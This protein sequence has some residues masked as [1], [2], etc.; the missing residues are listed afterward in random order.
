MVSKWICTCYIPFVTLVF[1]S[2]P[3]AVL[4]TC[5]IF[6]ELAYGAGTLR[7]LLGQLQRA[8]AARA[9]LDIAVRGDEEVVAASRGLSVWRMPLNNHERANYTIDEAP[10]GSGAFDQARAALYVRPQRRPRTGACASAPEQKRD[11]GGAS[12]STRVAYTAYLCCAR[13]YGITRH[14][15]PAAGWEAVVESAPVGSHSG[16]P[17]RWWRKRLDPGRHD[18]CCGDSWG[19]GVFLVPLETKAT[20]KLGWQFW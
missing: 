13:H 14:P 1:L 20:S 10:A 3:A 16:R 12:F 18:A 5:S 15:L 17:C 9:A 8:A 11:G 19:T 2:V 4:T 6:A 7:P